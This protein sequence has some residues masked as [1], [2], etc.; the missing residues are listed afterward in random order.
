[1][2]TQ[3]TKLFSFIL[4]C[5]HDPPPSS[6]QG[7]YMLLVAS[8]FLYFIACTHRRF[9]T[10]LSFMFFAC[11][12]SSLTILLS[13]SLSSS[14]VIWCYGSCIYELGI[15]SYSFQTS[16]ESNQSWYIGINFHP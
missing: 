13:N 7:T 9:W 6:H 15:R 11:T 8:A 14:S 5:V 2:T 12:T 4:A 10:P 16:A 1:M 3:F